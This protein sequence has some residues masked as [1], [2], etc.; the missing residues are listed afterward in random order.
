MRVKTIFYAFLLMIFA[1]ML[2][3]GTALCELKALEDIELSEIYAEGFSDFRINDLG[4]GITET[5]AW[6]NIH[7]YE[8]IEIESLK[9][10]YHDEYDYKDPTP[11]FGW[12]QDWENVVIGTD[13]E[14]PS[15]D[16][17]AE[18]FYFA[19][20]F[21][22]IDNPATRELKSFKFGVD[23]AQGD[24]SADFINFSG[25]IDDSNDNT[26]EYNGHALN[27]GNATITADPG[28]TGNGGF[29]ISLSIDDY[30]KGYW[31]TFDNATVTP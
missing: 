3:P 22:N 18:G 25:T 17:H 8:Y 13:Y 16:F 5:V 6:F 31:V 21:E 27:L 30:D 2:I 4:G 20:E 23:Y 10:G 15:T 29:S 28:N 24:I 9:L 7:T 12:D 14:D 11:S 19:A 1:V 26:P